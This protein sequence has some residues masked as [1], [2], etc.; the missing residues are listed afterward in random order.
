MPMDEE[1]EWLDT[2]NRVYDSEGAV[3]YNTGKLV[4]VLSKPIVDS[5]VPSN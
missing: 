4:V 3:N 5:D 1:E 2:L